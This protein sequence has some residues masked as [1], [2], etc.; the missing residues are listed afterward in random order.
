MGIAMF[1]AAKKTTTGLNA[2]TFGQMYAAMRTTHHILGKI[3][4]LLVLVLAVKP[5]QQINHS[6]NDNQ[7]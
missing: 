3:F 2:L 1:R 7:Q 4:I 6:R 5:D